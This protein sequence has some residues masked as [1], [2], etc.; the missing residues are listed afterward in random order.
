[1]I[2]NQAFDVADFLMS[3]FL[4]VIDRGLPLI[5]ISVF[6][7]HLFSQS[8]MFVRAGCLTEIAAGLCQ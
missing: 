4:I 7:R 5:S 3:I 1:M 6:P 8:C 2:Y